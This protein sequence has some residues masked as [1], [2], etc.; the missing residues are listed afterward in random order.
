MLNGEKFESFRLSWYLEGVEALRAKIREAAVCGDVCAQL[1]AVKALFLR[2]A[3]N[4][5]DNDRRLLTGEDAARFF[6]LTE[7]IAKDLS[8]E[9]IDKRIPGIPE[10]FRRYLRRLRGEGG[11]ELPTAEIRSIMA[12][13]GMLLIE[14]FFDVPVESDAMSG[15]TAPA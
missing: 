1:D 7:A 13:D 5:G 8:S 14:G 10:H 12:V 9:C 3:C 4:V 11:Q 6:A 15:A 2:F